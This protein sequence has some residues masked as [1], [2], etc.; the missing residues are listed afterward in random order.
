[1]RF[2]PGSATAATISNGLQFG[3]VLNHDGGI[4]IWRWHGQA[5]FAQDLS[6]IGHAPT[7]FVQTVFDRMTDAGESLQVSRVKS[8][9]IGILGRLDNE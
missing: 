8:K 6:V 9:K 1:M 3:L 7:R 4:W 2:E 5:L